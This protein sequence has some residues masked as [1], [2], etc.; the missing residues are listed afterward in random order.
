MTNV[1]CERQKCINYNKT[2]NPKKV[3]KSGKVISGESV[4]GEQLLHYGVCDL[5][6]I[7][8]RANPSHRGEMVSQL[9]FG[10][11]FEILKHEKEWFKIRTVFDGYQGWVDAF[12]VMPLDERNFI[13]I[14]QNNTYFSLERTHTARSVYKVQSILLGTPLPFYDNKEFSFFDDKY[15]FDGK[16]VNLLEAQEPKGEE[17][18]ELA[19]RFLNVPYLWGG[20]T[21]I[22]VDCSGFV[23]TVYKLN[24]IRLPRDSYQQALGGEKVPDITKAK[25]GD[26]AFFSNEFG[27][28][29]HVGILLNHT[30]I[31]H[32]SGKVR[33]DSIDQNGIY[34]NK[35]SIYTHRLTTIRRFF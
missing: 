12:Q 34:N 6:I 30:Q 29:T 21:P 7:P 3:L 24:N 18:K 11:T 33:L 25:T 2:P 26:L 15:H 19:M 27:K 22:G 20:R 28:I 32:A 16:V 14:N 9:L 5:T 8:V 4:K 10:E 23:Q 31:I 35:R 13:K 17:I 1:I